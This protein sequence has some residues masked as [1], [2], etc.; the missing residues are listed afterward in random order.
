MKKYLNEKNLN[1]VA[2]LATNF[3]NGFNLRK[4][5][6]LCIDEWYLGNPIDEHPEFGGVARNQYNKLLLGK[7]YNQ[8]GNTS[9]S[10]IMVSALG[11][12]FKEYIG[13]KYHLIQKATYKYLDYLKSKSLENIYTSDYFTLWS[14]KEYKDDHTHQIL[15]LIIGKITDF[16]FGFEDDDEEDNYYDFDFDDDF[17]IDDIISE[18]DKNVDKDILEIQEPKKEST[19]SEKTVF[20]KSTKK[21]AATKKAKK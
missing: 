18:I 1:F 14:F 17:N 12:F 6:E 3:E 11:E 10:E 16:K 7:D 21:K 5:V 2:H 9:V 19:K 15:C 4:A 20:K 8:Y 13:P